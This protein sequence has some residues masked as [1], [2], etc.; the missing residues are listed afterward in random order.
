MFYTSKE[1]TQQP[2]TPVFR[3]TRGVSKQTG[4]RE[5]DV[6]W[7]VK[8]GGYRRFMHPHKVSVSPL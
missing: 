4:S 2:Q 7:D 5:K 8:R 6:H 3:F 1:E